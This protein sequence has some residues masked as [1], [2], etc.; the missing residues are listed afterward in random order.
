MDAAGTEAGTSIGAPGCGGTKAPGCVVGGPQD[1]VCGNDQS[2]RPAK[3]AIVTCGKVSA[4]AG[5]RRLT[6]SG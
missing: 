4:Q 1:A 2:D 3:A 6:S 5:G